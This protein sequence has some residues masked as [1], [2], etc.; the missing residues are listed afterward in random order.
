[1]TNFTHCHVQEPICPCR[2]GG[3]RSCPV[4]P[5]QDFLLPVSWIFVCYKLIPQR[6]LE[7]VKHHLPFKEKYFP[8]IKEWEKKY[9]YKKHKNAT[10]VHARPRNPKKQIKPSQ[11]YLLLFAFNSQYLKP[12]LQVLLGGREGGREQDDELITSNILKII[13]SS[14]TSVQRGD[15]GEGAVVF[16]TPKSTVYIHNQLSSTA[17]C[18]RRGSK[19]IYRRLI[20]DYKSPRK[21]SSQHPQ[22]RGWFIPNI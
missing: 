14:D 12:S 19:Q 20:L 6:H 16:H 2:Y 13:C 18:F 22:V 10:K 11:L 7:D 3:I 8:A 4:L 21:F 15:G 1:M 17:T 9:I 5:S